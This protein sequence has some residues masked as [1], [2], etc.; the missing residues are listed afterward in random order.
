MHANCHRADLA[1]KDALKEAHVFLDVLND[2]LQHVAAYYNSAPARLKCFKGIASELGVAVTKFGKL[3]TK[4]WAAFAFGALRSMRRGNVVVVCALHAM[5]PRDADD[6]VKQQEL[7]YL[8]TDFV[9]VAA[10]HFM[11]DVVGA[12][13]GMSQTMQLQRRCVALEDL[14]VD[15]CIEALDKA[16]RWEGQGW[17]DFQKDFHGSAPV[18]RF[19]GVPLHNTEAEFSNQANNFVH[20][21]KTHI[22]TRFSES[23]PVAKA[24]RFLD[25][26]RWPASD[27]VALANYGND[28]VQ[29]IATHFSLVLGDLPQAI[30]QFT[31][32]KVRLCKQ[33]KAGA[34]PLCHAF[35]DKPEPILVKDVVAGFYQVWDAVL[36]WDASPILQCFEFL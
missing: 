16:E 35:Q 14:S 29:L 24:T 19:L 4:R 7:L 26:F 25:F 23:D 9:F 34:F 28:S 5:K 11:L 12:C 2:G 3:E 32:L 33:I 21:L 22:Q 31:T 13:A 8:L 30:H 18:P 15:K 17:R 36:R 1:F 10:L 27:G 6:A 20:S